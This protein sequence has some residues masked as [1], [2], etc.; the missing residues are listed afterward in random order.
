MVSSSPPLLALPIEILHQILE[1]V[2]NPRIRD[3]WRSDNVDTSMILPISQVCRQLREIVLSY[4]ALWNSIRR[5]DAMQLYGVRFDYRGEIIDGS[6][7]D[8]AAQAPFIKPLAAP[9]R[10]RKNSSLAGKL[11]ADDPKLPEAG[12]FVAQDGDVHKPDADEALEE[13]VPFPKPSPE[14]MGMKKPTEP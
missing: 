2:P 5:T 10:K 11:R 8:A 1:L 4:P 7:T 6:A 14:E 12:T 13:H 3:V 9:R